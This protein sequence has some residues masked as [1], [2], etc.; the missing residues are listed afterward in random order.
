MASHSMIVDDKYS[1]LLRNK[2]IFSHK[3][4][5][6]TIFLAIFAPL[7]AIIFNNCH[8]DHT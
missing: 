8:I 2:K 4:P 6:T 3:M 1:N 5:K 7:S